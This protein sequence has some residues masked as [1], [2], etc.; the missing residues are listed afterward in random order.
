M[1]SPLSYE[2]NA[3]SVC[4]VDLRETRLELFNLDGQG[5]P[6]RNFTALA[7]NL[8]LE[9]RELA[10]AMNAGMYDEGLKPIGLYI[11]DGGQERS[12]TAATAPAIFT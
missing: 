3:Y 10:F 11:E 1:C 8:S 6:F 12:R 5:G 7:E 4:R 9:D 2:G